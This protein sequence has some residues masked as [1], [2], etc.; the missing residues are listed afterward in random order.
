VRNF[1]RSVAVDIAQSVTSQVNRQLDVLLGIYPIRK[2]SSIM[3]VRNKKHSE[4]ALMKT[5]WNR[6]SSKVVLI[7]QYTDLVKMESELH[8]EIEYLKNIENKYRGTK[9]ADRK[10]RYIAYKNL[11]TIYQILEMPDKAIYYANRIRANDFRKYN[12]TALITSAQQMKKLHAIHN[13]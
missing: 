5:F 2:S 9:K 8:S 12:S 10:M 7:N 1:Q 11:A 3:I 6:I 13:L 4:Y